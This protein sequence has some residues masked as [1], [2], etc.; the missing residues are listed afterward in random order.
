MLVGDPESED[1]KCL[2]NCVNSQFIP[3]KVLIVSDGQNDSYLK[4][5]LEIL[6]TLNKINSKATAY[7]CENYTCSLPVTSVDELFKLLK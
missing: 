6:Q 3:N 2:I 7:V 5:K 1:L 4:S